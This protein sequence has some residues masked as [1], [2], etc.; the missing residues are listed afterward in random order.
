MTAHKDITGIEGTWSSYFELLKSAL[1]KNNVGLETNDKGE[2]VFKV[3]YPLMEGARILGQMILRPR[4]IDR[5][6]IE[7]RDEIRGI[8]RQKTIQALLFRMVTQG[9]FN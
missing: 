8:E 6:R 5:N 9:G 3:H 4:L 2:I 7:D 1:D